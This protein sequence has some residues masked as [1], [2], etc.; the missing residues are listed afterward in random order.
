MV[1]SVLRAQA[2]VGI[3]GACRPT[4]V[5]Q[6]ERGYEF[7]GPC[8]GEL[9]YTLTD[10]LKITAVARIDLDGI[11]GVDEQWHLQVSVR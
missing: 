5:R 9:R 11:T 7:Q 3:R 8:R 6:L 2:R 10:A 4:P 1:G